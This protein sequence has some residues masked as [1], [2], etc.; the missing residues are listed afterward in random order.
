MKQ[1]CLRNHDTF[2]CGREKSHK[3]KQCA[4]DSHREWNKKHPDIIKARWQKWREANPITPKRA[5]LKRMYNL[6]YGKYVFMLYLQGYRC[7]ICRKHQKDVQRRTLDIDH[8]HKTGKVRGL[9]CSS[10]NNLLGRANDDVKLLQA[11][12]KYLHNSNK[13]KT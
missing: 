9:L 2:I 4:R 1:F 11:A 12:I 8:D 7:L 5:K 6:A 10:C 3:C 13:G